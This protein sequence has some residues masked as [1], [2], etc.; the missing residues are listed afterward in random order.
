[1][2]D[3]VGGIRERVSYD[4]GK[5]VGINE[6]ASAVAAAVRS[7]AAEG[8]RRLARLQRQL[9]LLVPHPRRH[10]RAEQQLTSA[11]AGIAANLRVF[12][13]SLSLLPPAV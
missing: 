9:P 10:R 13:L 5:R 4:V 3:T 11:A 2:G 8:R 12:S 7:S 1:V 6:L